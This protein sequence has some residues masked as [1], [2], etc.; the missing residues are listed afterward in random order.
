MRILGIDYGDSRIGLA[1]SDAMGWTAQ[2]VGVISEKDKERQLCRVIEYID[3][4]KADEIVIGMPKN[5]NGTFGE[6]AEVTKL[7]AEKLARRTGL[8]PIYWDERLSTAAAHKT[9][10]EGMVSGKK[11]KGLLDKIAAV[12]ILQGYLDSRQNLNGR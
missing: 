7:F 12:L 9:L 2:P 5:M 1:V 6:R 4:L 10:Q 8:E 3:E 11:R